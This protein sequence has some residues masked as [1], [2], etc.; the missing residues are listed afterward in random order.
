MPEHILM[1]RGHE[2]LRHP[3]D[4][5]RK[6][7]EAA[8]ESRSPRLGFM[9]RDHHRV[10]DTVVTEIPRMGR[11]LAP[12]EVAAKAGLPVPRAEAILE[13]LESRLFFLVRDEKGGVSWAYPVTSEA[14][15]HRLELSTGESTYA[16]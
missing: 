15:P 9:T 11:P 13:E 1:G 3:A 4:A 2:I 12:E 8:L 6:H 7:L 10:R 16:A 14:T 5:F